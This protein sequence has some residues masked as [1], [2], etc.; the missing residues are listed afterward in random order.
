M[1]NKVKYITNVHIEKDEKGKDTL[2]VKAGGIAQLKMMIHP[3]LIP[4]DYETEPED[5]IFEMDFSLEKNSEA[6]NDVDFEVEV[7]C[8]FRNIPDWVTGIRINAEE[9][10]DI[11]LL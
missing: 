5:G 1:R 3:S 6:S 9:N 2:V 10:S 8:Y 4:R 11:E 7:V